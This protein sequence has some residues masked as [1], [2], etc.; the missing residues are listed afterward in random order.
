MISQILLW[1]HFALATYAQEIQFPASG[2]LNPGPGDTPQILQAFEDAGRQPNAS[3]S[4]TF[5]RAS[6]KSR[7]SG[8][9]ASTSPTWQSQIELQTW[10][11]LPQAFPGVLVSPTPNGSFC[12]LAAMRASWSSSGRARWKYCLTPL[13]FRNR[14]T[15]QIRTMPTTTVTVPSF[16]AAYV[17]NQSQKPLARETY[18]KLYS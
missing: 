1:A 2:T 17:L 13:Q 3:D 6:T 15:S 8:H 12:G 7:R 5:F 10:V 16:S 18:S 4:I 9:G 11:L 14:Q